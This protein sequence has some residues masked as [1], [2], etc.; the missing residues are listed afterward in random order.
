V[1]A[2]L[3]LAALA[4][5]LWM[6][7]GVLLLAFGG[8]LFAV[9]LSALAGVFSRRWHLSWRASVASSV[10]LLLALASAF[11]YWL[12]NELAAQAAQLSEQLP[13]A[14]EAFRGW[15]AG[16]PLGP[17]IIEQWQQLRSDGL[18]L[19]RVA[20]F[21]AL[22]AGALGNFIL[23]LLLAIFLT[24][25]PQLYRRGALRLLPVR[26]RDTF[27]GALDACGEA[28]RGWLKGQ[29]VS[30]LFVGAATAAGL[31]LLGVP[32]ALLLGVLAGILN[33]VPFFGPIASGLLAVLLAFV[34][35]PQTALYVALLGLA[36]QQVEGNLM[37]PLVQRWAVQLP[38]ALGLVAVL[39]AAAIFGLPGILLATPMMVVGMVL[40]RKLYVEAALERGSATAGGSHGRT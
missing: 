32:L 28:L 22:V 34:Q 5:L 9:A 23:M 13:R 3:A 25:E 11:A 37:M 27:A 21:A 1:A 24:A 15:L 10:L 26:H 4:A 2:A 12:G 20:G 38:P 17:Q 19:G 39:V 29:A 40:V 8:L 16:K 14:V 7:R 36:I 33:F 30:M 35:G 6:F 18:P 31:W